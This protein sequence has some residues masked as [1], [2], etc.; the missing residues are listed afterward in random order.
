MVAPGRVQSD[1]ITMLFERLGQDLTRARPIRDFRRSQ[2][3]AI[4]TEFDAD[5]DQTDAAVKG[6]LEDQISL[7]L[8]D[9]HERME[10]AARK[11]SR[12]DP[13]CATL[14]V[15]WLD[16]SFAV[17]AKSR[18]RV[19]AIRFLK[20]WTAAA[21]SR[22][23][24]RRSKPIERGL[25]RFLTALRSDEH[26]VRLRSILVAALCT[27]AVLERGIDNIATLRRTREY[28]E[29]HFG[30]FNKAFDFRRLPDPS[31]EFVTLLLGKLRRRLCELTI[32][33]REGVDQTINI[34]FCSQ[35]ISRRRGIW[36]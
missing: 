20:R 18:D 25:R 13:L 34:V 30:D 22:I 4:G 14:L 27:E 7:T 11:L 16:C 21:L 23:N 19:S 35:K 12:E 8:E 3:N 10:L 24:L 36:G 26:S 32:R 15:I 9:M 6:K 31:S 1:L 5:E 28:I 17:Y 2:E 29:S 33:S